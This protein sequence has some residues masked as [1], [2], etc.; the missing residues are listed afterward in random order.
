MVALRLGREQF[1][2][3][4]LKIDKNAGKDTCSFHIRNKKQNVKQKFR[5][6]CYVIHYGFDPSKDK[7]QNTKLN[8]LPVCPPFSREI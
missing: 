7:S 6:P 2:E 1:D 8:I 5:F 3:H 4:N